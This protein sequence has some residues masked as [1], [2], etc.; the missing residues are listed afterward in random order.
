M[1]WALV[2]TFMVWTGSGMYES[3]RVELAYQT[4]ALCERAKAEAM[5]KI[6]AGQ[7]LIARCV[8]KQ[9]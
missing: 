1:T 7:G 3:K 6:D 5:T 4:Q 2:M 8:Q 9:A